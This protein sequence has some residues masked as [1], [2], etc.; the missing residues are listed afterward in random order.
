MPV[1]IFVLYLRP[2]WCSLVLGHQCLQVFANLFLEQSR[3][4]LKREAVAQAKKI[5]KARRE[6]FEKAQ[7]KK[8][9]EE[10]DNGI[11]LGSTV[12]NQG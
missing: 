2:K 5:Q 9:K 4:L 6:S 8:N 10:S 11:I 12:G 7:K 1:L 3:L